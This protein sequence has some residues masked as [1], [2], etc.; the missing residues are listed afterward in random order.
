[1][2]LT[3]RTQQRW[4][5]LTGVR[6]L[7]GGDEVAL[8]IRVGLRQQLL[9]QRHQR[10]ARAEQARRTQ[11]LRGQP[12]MGQRFCRDVSGASYV[13][14]HLPCCVSRLNCDLKMF[15]L[16]ARKFAS[17]RTSALALLS[18]KIQCRESVQNRPYNAPR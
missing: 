7:S 1:M 6:L 16:M 10:H 3:G 15:Q 11:P 17:V 2:A 12:L 5:G 9:R 4:D 13:L 18:V 14:Q 8:V